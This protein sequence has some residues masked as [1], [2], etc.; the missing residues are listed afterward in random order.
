MESTD[1]NP[2]AALRV[3]LGLKFE[4]FSERLGCSKGHAHD[5][6]TGRKPV[7]VPIAHKLESIS[8][9]PWHEW[10]TPPDDPSTDEKTDAAA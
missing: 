9:R 7:T 1:Q 4:D 3:A 2:V 8:G 6:C 10:V 5:I